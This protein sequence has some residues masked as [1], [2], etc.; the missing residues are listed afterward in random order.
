MPYEQ[1]QYPDNDKASVRYGG[2]AMASQPGVRFIADTGWCMPNTLLQEWSKS[3]N[4]APY[5]SIPH[6]SRMWSQGLGAQ[7]SATS[8]G[9]PYQDIYLQLKPPPVPAM[10]M[11]AR[12]SMAA[13][14]RPG[15]GQSG[16]GYNMRIPST[17]VPINYSNPGYR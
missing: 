14:I 5:N 16:F 13:V 10:Q 12:G 2:A 6:L 9:W 7:A 15:G 17:P 4:T 1:G 8:Y 11:M 3:Y